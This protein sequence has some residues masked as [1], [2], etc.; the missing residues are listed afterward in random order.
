MHC[1]NLILIRKSELR[2]SKISS[3][4]DDGTFPKLSIEYLNLPQD[5]M[6]FPNLE[7]ADVCKNFGGGIIFM[8]I[9]TDYFGGAGD[10]SASLNETIIFGDNFHYK[11]TKVSHDVDA[12][13][14]LLAEYGVIRV[15]DKDEFDS[16]D[17]GRYRSND[18]YIKEIRKR[19]I[20]Q[21]TIDTT[22]SF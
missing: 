8:A 3:I 13:D 22:K 4:I 18:D 10:Q 1:V 7:K 14:K 2:N 17:L 6:A 11:K 21:Q 20:I 12:I 15:G 9:S 5:I 19:K 16:I